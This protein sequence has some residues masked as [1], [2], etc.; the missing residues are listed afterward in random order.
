MA[1]LGEKIVIPTDATPSS[2]K[3]DVRARIVTKNGFDVTK[4]AAGGMNQLTNIM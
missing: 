2:M 1:W 4:H 3:L